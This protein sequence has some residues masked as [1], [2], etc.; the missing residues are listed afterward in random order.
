MADKQIRIEGLDDLRA[1]LNAIWGL[2]AQGLTAGPVVITLGRDK[3]PAS[4]NRK[5]WPLLQDISQQLEWHGVSMPEAD[6][7]DLF[8]A[9]QMNQRVVPGID[10]G[11]VALS[12]STSGMEPAP[13]ADLIRLIYAFGAHQGVKWSDPS[14]AVY[15]Q[16]KEAAA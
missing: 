7:K 16:Y 5:L 2:V 8:A 14:L 1:K 4:M 15:E 12:N 9:R 13:F 6:W 10:G 11:L 3:R